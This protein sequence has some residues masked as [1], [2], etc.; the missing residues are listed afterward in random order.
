MARL[1]RIYER[2]A[3]DVPE[4]LRAESRWLLGLISHGTHAETIRSGMGRYS[5]E[6]IA[7]LLTELEALQLVKSKAASADHDLDFTGSLSLAAL[8]AAHNAR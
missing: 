8:S 4:A 3:A 6:R 2:T 5:D 7:E 1:D